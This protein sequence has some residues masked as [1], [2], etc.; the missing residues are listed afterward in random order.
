MR[1]KSSKSR[2]LKR[3]PKQP[4]LDLTPPSEFQTPSRV[5][6]SRGGPGLKLQVTPLSGSEARSFV[7]PEHNL[8]NIPKIKEGTLEPGEKGNHQTIKLMEKIAR[9]RSGD[10]TIRKFALNILSYYQV[11][12]QDYAKEALAIGD[13]VKEKVRYVRDPDGI[14]YLQDPVDMIKQMAKGEA[15][16]DC[17]DM[18]LLIATLLLAIGH[19]PYFRT[20]RYN[21]QFGHYNHIYVVVY[22]KNVGTAP[23]RIV[24][25][26][27]I[28]TQPIGFEVSHASGD[29]W[30][31]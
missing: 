22:E 17:D 6:R 19:R 16:G 20:V 12:S 25:D 1:S 3:S 23:M 21:T 14:E 7:A 5:V 8:G 10:P 30:A 27:I 28:K 24:L 9:Q 31:V 15:Q 4:I 26:A 13:Y 11:P 2:P 18:S 29:E